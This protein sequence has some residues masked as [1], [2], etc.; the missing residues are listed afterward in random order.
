METF[1]AM[2]ELPPAWWVL[3]AIG[4]A[5]AAS[6]IWFSRDLAGNLLGGGR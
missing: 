3:V 4:A 5:L 6:A 1:K 2:M